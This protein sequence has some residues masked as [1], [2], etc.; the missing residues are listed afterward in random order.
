[1]V[2]LIVASRDPIPSASVMARIPPWWWLGG[3]FG[4]GFIGLAILL[5]PRIGATTFFALLI[6]GQ[7]L[8]SLA[9]DHFGW[10][11]LTER[12]VDPMRLAGV[13]L[14]IAGVIL[15]RR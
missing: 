2:A 5:V 3:I 7:M 10:F 15:I 1:M 11:G 9:F 12:P 13:A 8:A 6:T 4:A 14:L